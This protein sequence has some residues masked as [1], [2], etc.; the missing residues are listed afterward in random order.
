MKHL[1]LKDVTELW[2]KRMGEFTAEDSANFRWSFIVFD[3]EVFPD[4]VLLTTLNM[5]EGKTER[6]WGTRNIYAY[7]KKCLVNSCRSVFVGFNCKGY[8]N[9]ISDSILAGGDEKYVKGVNDTLIANGAVSWESGVNGRRPEWVGRT[10]D[11]GFDIGQRKIGTPPNEKKIPEISLKRW[12]RLN[13][14]EVCHS[15]VPFDKPNITESE[16]RVVEKYCEYDV[17]A[18]AMLLLSDEA[19]N[20]C[21]NARRVLI[22]D[23]S[24]KGVD[25]EM[26]KPRI[27][28]IVLNARPEQFD[29]PE[30]WGRHHYPLPKEIRLWKNRDVLKMY[31]SY[32][33][34]QLRGMSYKATDGEG[35]LQKN[36]NG[37]PHI[38]G[39]GGVHGC[40]EGIW[41]CYDGGIYSLDASSLYPN[42]M[43]H[44]GFLSRKV[45]GRDRD[46]FGELID[47]RTKVYKPRGDKRADGLKLV[48]N[49]GFGSMGFQ[50]SD[51]YDPEFF[52][53][54]TITGQL[55]ITDLLEKLERRIDLIQTNTDGIFFRLKER[56]PESLAEC[57][58]I[59]GDFEKRTHLE[60]EWTEF[61]KMYQRDISNYVAQCVPKKEGKPGKIKKKGTW[62]S[63]KHCTVTPY[64]Q[65]SRIYSALN[66][67]K[68][69]PP[70][71]FNMERFSIEC[72]RDKNSMCFSVDDK[73]L[74]DE[75]IDVVPVKP[76]SAKAQ[77]IEVVTKEI[78]D[79]V[80]SSVP[81]LFGD[82][83]MSSIGAHKR[84][85]ATGCPQFASLAKDASVEDVD[86]DWYKENKKL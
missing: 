30:D 19:W 8:D 38:Y 61:E 60:M 86:L 37:I 2:K 36:V 78:A 45:R 52:N 26:T 70:D 71:G 1:E 77:R 31:T 14:F 23:Y 65:E 63:V 80:S 33:F 6:V 57:R 29:V 42:I 58:S 62:Y 83:D 74:Y 46:K 9:H 4:N 41:K 85:K 7:L 32:S 11:I 24:S 18:T 16:K 27:T 39:I 72:K 47:L 82:A 73:P 25:W 34:D 81:S 51:M 68:T 28:A 22:D 44:Y 20:P 43:R 64:L 10:F 53:C 35:V 13:G 55:L 76:G 69:L 56:T 50:K 21:L 40:I 48:L 49:G 12:E 84:R 54:V 59:V 67:G 17:L 15:P 5:R 66:D 75:W 79:D 3:Y